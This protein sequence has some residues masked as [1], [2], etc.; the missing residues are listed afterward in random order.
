MSALLL[1]SPLAYDIDTL[2]YP[3]TLGTLSKSMR[4]LTEM[5]DRL[6]ETSLLPSSS[7]D[8]VS[9]LSRSMRQLSEMADRLADPVASPLSNQLLAQPSLSH[10]AIFH[11]L[12]SVPRFEVKETSDGMIVA[13]AT[14]GLRKE[15]LSV[16]VIDTPSGKMLEVSGESKHH[17]PPHTSGTSVRSS[18]VKFQRQIL[19]PRHVDP[20]SL[21][22]RYHDGLLEVTLGRRAITDQDPGRVKYA[23]DG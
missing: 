7:P 1:R 9:A 11:E 10:Q 22:A 19:L 14:P 5:A 4:R 12:V 3:H 18:Y 15:D 13:C 2:P 20:E 23:I 6:A 17:D 8:Q 21:K 16:E